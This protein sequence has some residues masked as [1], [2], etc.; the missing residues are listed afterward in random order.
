MTSNLAWMEVTS[1]REG[2]RERGRA[3]GGSEG[4]GR[5]GGGGGREEG[6]R[7]GVRGRGMEGGREGKSEGGVEEGRK[8]VTH[9]YHVI[10]KGTSVPLTVT[11]TGRNLSNLPQYLLLIGHPSPAGSGESVPHSAVDGDT[12]SHLGD[13]WPRGP[14]RRREVGCYVR[15]VESEVSD[16]LSALPVG[17]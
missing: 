11:I 3:E 15:I 14:D 5:D 6:E 1:E 12:H 9:A 16:E 17:S 13:G 4:G 7:E 8:N 2:G 10:I